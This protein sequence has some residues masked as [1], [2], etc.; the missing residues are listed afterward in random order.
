MWTP[1]LLEEPRR[2]QDTHAERA[3]KGRGLSGNTDLDHACQLLHGILHA[4]TALWHN[5]IERH[6]PRPATR[7]VWSA[8]QSEFAS[9]LS[10]SLL[11]EF[12]P[13][14]AGASL[15][16]YKQECQ[17]QTRFFLGCIIGLPTS[18][19]SMSHTPHRMP[20]PLDTGPHFVPA[21]PAH[22]SAPSEQRQRATVRA[23]NVRELMNYQLSEIRVPAGKTGRVGVGRCAIDAAPAAQRA[24]R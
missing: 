23:R 7:W 9:P 4:L 3:G 8:F 6:P 22:P 11:L 18:R 10:T 20:G 24:R 16:S 14:F 1:L 17:D 12:L 15:G 13:R 19:S 21:S 5:E 2:R